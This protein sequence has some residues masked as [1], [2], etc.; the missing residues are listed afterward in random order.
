[1]AGKGESTTLRRWPVAGVAWLVGLIMGLALAPLVPWG[2][3]AQLFTSPATPTPSATP[4]VPTATPPPPPSPT[5]SPTVVSAPTLPS[6]PTPA[7]SATATSSPTP[8]AVFGLAWFHKP[9]EDDSTAADIA[10]A[11]RYIHLTGPADLE[12]RD[13]L[14][15]AGYSGPIYDY[16]TAYAVEGPG[17]YKSAAAPCAAGY[18][19]YDDQMAWATDDFCTYIHPNESWF[20]HNSKGERLVYDYFGTGHWNYFMNPADPGWQA[21]SYSRLR[22]A[23]DTWEYDGVWLDNLDFDLNRLVKE[24]PNSDGTVR[25]YADDDAWRAG[26]QEWL[27]GLR[28]AVGTWPIWANLT[29]NRDS[30]DAWDAYAPYLDGAMEESFAVRWIEDWLTPAA[31]DVQQER[32]AR[33]LGAGKGLVMVGQGPQDDAERLRFTL[34]SYLL[35]AEGDQAF[36]RYTRFDSYYNNLWLYPEFD[37]ARTLGMPSGPRQEIRPGVWRR[38]FA[39]GYVEVDTGRHTGRLELTGP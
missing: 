30:A 34:A 22:Y 21:F 16:V 25:E 29:G 3:T 12:F 36:Y 17:P 10:A 38:P 11:H 35:V 28:G 9:P 14:R 39:H 37:T 15:Q 7:P 4:S 32:A 2:G 27:A 6:S 19:P 24:L 31:W 26:M 23:R 8:A 20:L 1:M 5:R 18:E 33:W 13:E